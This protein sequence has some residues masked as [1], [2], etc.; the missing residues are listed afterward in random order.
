MKQKIHVDIQKN[1]NTFHILV[2]LSFCILVRRFRR[3]GYF[4]L[5]SLT[6]TIVNS[7]AGLEVSRLVLDVDIKYICIY[8]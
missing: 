7:E 4:E 8:V 5:L 1:L 3:S 2:C 6:L